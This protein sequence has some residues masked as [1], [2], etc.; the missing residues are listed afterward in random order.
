MKIIKDNIE[1]AELKEM[2]KKMHG[3]FVKAI[4]DIEKEIMTVESEFHSDLMEF[5]IKEEN[6]EPKNLWGI[7][8]YPDLQ[9]D[10]FIMFDSMRWLQKSTFGLNY[11][12]STANL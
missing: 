3:E 4:V 10:D 9:G 8:I 1:I 12:F 11:C 2:A 7:N 6:S 5:L